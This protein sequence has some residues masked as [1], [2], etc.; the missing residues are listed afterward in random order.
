M[1][2]VNDPHPWTDGVGA[3]LSMAEL[4]ANETIPAVPAAALWWAVERGAS[5]LT[6]G[7]PSGAGKTTLA[8]ACLTFLPDD[9]RVHAVGGA[10]DALELATEGGPTHLLV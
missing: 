2:Y 1:Q 8:N 6:A 9:A 3:D 10:E 5:L 7:G 4:V